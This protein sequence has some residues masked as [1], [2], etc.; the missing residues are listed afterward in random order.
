MYINYNRGRLH[1]LQFLE[2]VRKCVREMHAATIIVAWEFLLI[3][4]FYSQIIVCFSIIGKCI[5]VL[6]KVN[7]LEI[8][9]VKEKPRAK[10]FL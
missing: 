1:L 3:I 2:K 8:Q 9:R 4:L 5:D 6:L 7:H 10:A